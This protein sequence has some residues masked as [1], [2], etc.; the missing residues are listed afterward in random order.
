MVYPKF[1]IPGVPVDETE[2]T[3]T[4]TM[5]QATARALYAILRGAQLGRNDL[6]EELYRVYHTLYGHLPERDGMKTQHYIDLI[7]QGLILG[8]KNTESR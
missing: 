6:G 2:I 8:S 3:T 5:S 4:L 1:E 7:R